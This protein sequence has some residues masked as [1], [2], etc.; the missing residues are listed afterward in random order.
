M[1]SLQVSAHS[2]C[3]NALWDSSV[4]SKFMEARIMQMDLGVFTNPIDL[5]Y[6][7][8]TAIVIMFLAKA[9]KRF[10]DKIVE[11][12]QKKREQAQSGA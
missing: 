2:D 11:K 6:V 5:L 12:R 3:A 7:G 8:A 1:A 4:V 9:L 10:N